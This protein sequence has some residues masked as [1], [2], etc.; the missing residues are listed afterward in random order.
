MTVQ[1]ARVR[2]W[3]ITA[4]AI[5]VVIGL[6][7]WAGR[8]PDAPA[9]S[10]PSDADTVAVDQASPALAAAGSSGGESSVLTQPD[11][12]EGVSAGDS[13][14]WE[15]QIQG[16]VVAED[17]QPAPSAS[18]AA[19][20]PRGTDLGRTR[21]DELG[22]FSLAVVVSG[23]PKLTCIL[24][25]STR[26]DGAALRSLPWYVTPQRPP[27]R[28][29]TVL[30]IL[31]PGAII[32]GRVL[33]GGGS[34]AKGATVVAVFEPTRGEARVVPGWEVASLS[35]ELTRTV[36]GDDGAF[37]LIV[38]PGNVVVRA[39]MHDAHSGARRLQAVAGVRT[40]VG[41]VELST[42]TSTLRLR[43]VKESGDPVAGAWIQLADRTLRHGSAEAESTLPTLV[44]DSAGRVRIPGLVSADF[45]LVLAAGSPHD[46]PAEIT[47][48][49]APEDEL[50]L[51]LVPRP[52]LAL[53]LP[54]SAC[55]TDVGA[56]VPDAWWSFIQVKPPAAHGLQD[57]TSPSEMIAGVLQEDLVRIDA[58]DA[59]IWH[60]TLGVEAEYRA[61]I[62][63]RGSEQVD[64]DVRASRDGG[65]TYNV[66]LKPGRWVRM[67]AHVPTEW[68]GDFVCEWLVGGQPSGYLFDL[69]GESLRSGA[70]CF[71]P[72][73]FDEVQVRHKQ[74]ALLDVG[75]AQPVAIP[76]RGGEVDIPLRPA[77]PVVA[78]WVGVSGAEGGLDLSDWPIQILPVGPEGAPTGPGVTLRTSSDGRVQIATSAGGLRVVPLLRVRDVQ[79]LDVSS[80]QPSATYLVRIW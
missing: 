18:I 32:H 3:L 39:S 54:A 35:E 12:A 29:P 65:G 44:A 73:V 74:P 55:R 52:R 71:A 70:W 48:D 15:Y 2:L 9:L 6:S 14:V 51:R 80:P 27:A 68:R 20:G 67:R 33:D 42:D 31:R 13:D 16:L 38:R 28:A 36:S 58:S 45:P 4:A 21:A 30:L 53:R 59:C 60:V 17:G 1:A 25:E 8:G 47:V 57:M 69:T 34:P 76:P 79:P 24:A 23:P 46:G 10:G 41:V 49:A 43:V 22:R 40:D 72:D 50:V 78:I 56:S 75:T 7:V 63:L 62:A 37:E 77:T 64:L 66:P 61:S 5:A 11:F 19:I 26:A